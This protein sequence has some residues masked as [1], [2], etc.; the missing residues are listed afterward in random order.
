MGYAAAGNNRGRGVVADR[1]PAAAARAGDRDAHAGVRQLTRRETIALILVCVVSAAAG[2]G[3][4]E[5][6][7][8]GLTG[9][10][11]VLLTTIANNGVHDAAPS[12]GW[13]AA[14]KKERGISP[15][16]CALVSVIRA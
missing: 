4:T 7:L 1:N 14:D 16:S 13:Y 10:D 12:G 6:N 3:A 5:G 8:Q 11:A 9:L 15:P 2:F